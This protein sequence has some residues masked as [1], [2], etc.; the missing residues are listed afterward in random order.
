MRADRDIGGVAPIGV[1]VPRVGQTAES[2]AYAVKLTDIL[3][4]VRIRH[5]PRRETV[6]GSWVPRYFFHVRIGRE[7]TRDDEGVELLGIEA[8]VAEALKAAREYNDATYLPIQLHVEDSSG[9]TVFIVPVAPA[10]SAIVA[11]GSA[12]LALH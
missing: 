12:S 7:L 10:P 11:F 5:E 6:E 1:T 8:A 2:P 4:P 3:S 9:R